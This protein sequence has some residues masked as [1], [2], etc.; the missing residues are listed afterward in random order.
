MYTK[1]HRRLATT[2][3]CTYLCLYPYLTVQANRSIQYKVMYISIY[4][5]NDCFIHKTLQLE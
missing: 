3:H 2:L 4:F 1:Q 5:G